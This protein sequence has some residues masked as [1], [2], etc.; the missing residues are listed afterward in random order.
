MFGKVKKGSQRYREILLI[1]K[2]TLSAPKA[3][4]E[5]DWKIS[6]KAGRELFYEKAFSFWKNSCLPAKMQLMLLKILHHQL[7]GL[8]N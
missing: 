7:R 4:I 8:A 6:E 1:N 2:G 5:K 3:K